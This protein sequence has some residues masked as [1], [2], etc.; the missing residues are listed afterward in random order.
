MYILM[1]EY[2]IIY[3]YIIVGTDSP[4]EEC[5]HVPELELRHHLH[6]L[7]GYQLSAFGK[8]TSFISWHSRK[9]ENLRKISHTFSQL[10][11]F[12]PGTPLN[13]RS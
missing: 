4:V 3:T 7:F 13:G 11:A 5:R 9:V 10:G 6:P 8:S 12:V 1:Y 2:H